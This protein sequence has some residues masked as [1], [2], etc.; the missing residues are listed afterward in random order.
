MHKKWRSG[1]GDGRLPAPPTVQGGSCLKKGTRIDRFFRCTQ[2][3]DG[4]SPSRGHPATPATG[5]SAIS[6]WLHTAGVKMPALVIDNGAGL[7]RR[8]RVSAAGLAAL[9]EYTA[10]MAYF[11]EFAAS[12]PIAGVDGSLRTRF[13]GIAAAGRLR[14]KTGQLTGVR[15][16]AGYAT[17]RDGAR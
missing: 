14:L 15:A 5:A 16:L 4:F 12:L 13:Q 11:P 8:A 7:S 1:K 10:A 6:D 9:L 17:G 2:A 3:I